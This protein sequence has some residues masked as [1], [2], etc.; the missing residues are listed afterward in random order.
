MPR[1]L[2]G[3]TAR[4]TNWLLI[5]AFTA[6]GWAIYLRYTTLEVPAVALTCQAGLDTWLCLARRVVNEF[7]K[8]S[9]FGIVALGI[10]ALN[11]LRPSLVLLSAGLAMAGLGLVLY[12]T[13]LSAYAVALLA[14]S[15]ARPV[16]ASD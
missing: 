7:H 8:Y 13:M 5:V 9:V 1:R 14:L 6:V 11:L 3:P 10:A 4:Q 2:F 16:V 15:L 12:N